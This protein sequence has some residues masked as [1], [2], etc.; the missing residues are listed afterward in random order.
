[1]SIQSEQS[2]RSI[3]V[4]GRAY[5]LS[6]SQPVVV[7]CVD[8]CEYDYLEAAVAAGVAPFIG[9][10]MKEGTALKGDCVIPS[11]T[12]PNNLSIVCG[13]PPSVHGICGNYFWD[14]QANG[15]EGAEVMMND[16]AYLRAGTLLAEAA[17]AVAAVAVVTAKDK[18]RRLLGW[19]LKG[20]CFSAEKADTVTLADNGIADVLD[21]VGLPVPDV[22]SAGL[23]EFVFAAGVRLAETRKLDLMYLSTTD[24][25]QH[26]WAPGTQGAN[27]FYAMMDR[28]LAQLDA[29]G[30][31]I[32]L[33]A[34]HGMNAKHNPQTGEPNVIYLQDVM[35]EWLGARKARVILPITDPYVVHHGALGSFATI[36]LPHDVNVRQVI[37][38]IGG[39]D[40]V[41]VVLDNRAACERFELPNDRVGDIV[42]VSKRDVVL[43]TRRDEHDLSGLTVP[44]RSHGG[45]SEQEVP[46][47]FNRH[48]QGLTD[49]KRLRNFDV[50]DL[51]LNHVAAS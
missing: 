49:G 29:L 24:Y 7:V 36:Y 45:I 51:A 4:N 27:D 10:M 30:W 13:V 21:L 32:G 19:Q 34:D 25:I 22:Y 41:E 50:F 9:K 17:Q 46:L 33:T 2:E 31:V 1:M 14:P 40:G 38:R 37:E 26:K 6:S 35:D 48:L 20:I 16:P 47:I 11:F 28:Y 23:S 39:L 44:L 42:V 43:G 12:N 3:E 15:G 8:G 18:L 5:R